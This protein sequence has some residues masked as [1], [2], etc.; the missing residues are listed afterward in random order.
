MPKDTRI[1]VIKREEQIIIPEG[2]TLIESGDVVAALT[3]KENVPQLADL[4]N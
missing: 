1:I 3:L 4:F 2:E